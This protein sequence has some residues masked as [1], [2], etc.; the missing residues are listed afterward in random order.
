M[1]PRALSHA[2]VL[3]VDDE[4]SNVR[5][6]ERLLELAKAGPVFSVTDPRKALGVFLAERPDIV[7]LDLHMPQIDGFALLSQIKASLP[8][9]EYLPVLVL[10]ADITHETRQRALGKGAHDFLTKPIDPDEVLLRI[11][12]LLETRF[13]HLQL[14]RQ[15]EELERLVR[16]RTLQ[17][18]ET[19]GKLK[20][21]QEQLVKQERLRALGMMASGI[22]HDFNNALTMVL[23]YGELLS[24][25]FEKEVPEREREQFKHLIAAA[26]DAAHVVARL[27]DFYR[28]ADQDE[29]RVS[30]DVNLAVQQAVVLT[31][32]RWRDKCRAEGIQINVETDLNAVP[33]FLGHPPELREVLT[34]LIFNAVDAMPQGGL[35]RFST[36]AEDGRIQIAVAD[37]GVGMTEE[38]CSRCLEPFYTTKGP[39]GTGLGL[40]AVYGFVQRYGGSI[41]IKSTKGKGSV[42]TL[43]LPGTSTVRVEAAPERKERQRALRILVVDDQEI[44]RQ[45][46]AELLETEGHFAL[47]VAD[48]E[49][50][51]TKL[52]EGPWDLVVSDQSMPAM[53]GSQ[54][55]AEIRRRNIRVPFI[56]L[57]GFGD[58]MRAK[59]G[60]P[61]GVDL[62]LS[63]PVTAG[64]LRKALREVVHQD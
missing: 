8:A 45:L 64:S 18:E 52:A 43:T 57:T 47:A 58:E 51:L 17:L 29:L 46:I 55:A 14:Q 21:A 19:L 15:N 59:G 1:L 2:K 27:R 54:M 22:A 36:G 42:F 4:A 12:N 39:H 60:N 56:L 35:L 34:N 49:A 3:I 38:E 13:L 32:P 23:G 10:T 20:A 28:P 6:L 5:L 16:E 41:G 26:E 40:A 63:K 33:P 50:A 30:V 24:S 9:D 61:E 11:R 25:F 62:L 7:L 53:T 44:I 31:A 48:C 37:T